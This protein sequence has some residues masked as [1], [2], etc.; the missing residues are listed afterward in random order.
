MRFVTAR[1]NPELAD[2]I[3]VRHRSRTLAVITASDA[4]VTITHLTMSSRYAPD[5]YQRALRD[6]ALGA[7]AWL[8]TLHRQ[9]PQR[10]TL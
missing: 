9:G 5:A 4:G 7:R 3:Q 6:V 2:Q 1:I 10:L 8:A